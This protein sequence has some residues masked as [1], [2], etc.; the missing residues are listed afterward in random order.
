MY[1]LDHWSFYLYT[2]LQVQ[3]SWPLKQ[4]RMMNAKEVIMLHVWESYMFV[5]LEKLD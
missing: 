2:Y 5:T 3:I 4:H 1:L